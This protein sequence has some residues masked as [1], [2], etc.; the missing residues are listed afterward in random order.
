MKIPWKGIQRKAKKTTAKPRKVNATVLPNTEIYFKFLSSLPPRPTNIN[1]FA[2]DLV[3]TWRR[4]VLRGIER[5]E[6]LFEYTIIRAENVSKKH[7]RWIKRIP[8][9]SSI[10]AS[11]AGTKYVAVL[12]APSASGHSFD[13][14][15]VTSLNHVVRTLLF[16]VWML[17][18]EST[19]ITTKKKASRTGADL[20]GGISETVLQANFLPGHRL[21]RWQ[22]HG[23]A[24]PNGIGISVAVCAYSQ[25][26]LPTYTLSGIFPGND[27]DACQSAGVTRFLH[28]Y[29][30][31]I[32]IW[33]I[34]SS[35]ILMLP[36]PLYITCDQTNHQSLTRLHIL[37]HCEK[38]RL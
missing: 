23:V 38:L 16:H 30:P 26:M 11:N 31:L 27:E 25:V 1:I 21:D 18:E 4:V 12:R 37:Y 3:I 17:A 2:L 34:M 29:P 19:S 36:P 5:R 8:L 20:L 35:A 15:E 32:D 14:M 24:V 13:L 28:A 33:K 10:L 7:S 22:L 6:T 9:A